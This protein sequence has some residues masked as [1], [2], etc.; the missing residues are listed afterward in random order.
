MTVTVYTK[1]NCQP[2][3]GTKFALKK[4]GIDAHY[5]DI[6]EDH[7]ARD[8]VVSLGFKSTPVVMT[9]DGQS[10]SGYNPEKIKALVS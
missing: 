1:P 7:E 8:Y 9:S 5:I 6:T 2:C 4:H 10:W 3:N